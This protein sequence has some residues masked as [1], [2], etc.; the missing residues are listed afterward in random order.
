MDENSDDECFE[1][2]KEDEISN[3]S[4]ESYDQI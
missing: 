2:E 3:L 4:E 1:S